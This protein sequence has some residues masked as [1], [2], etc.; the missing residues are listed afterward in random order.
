[1]NHLFKEVREQEFTHDLKGR[2]QKR[3]KVSKHDKK[4]DVKGLSSMKMMFHTS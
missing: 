2:N 1:M 3:V 4:G